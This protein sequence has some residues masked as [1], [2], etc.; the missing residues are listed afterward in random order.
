MTTIEMLA[1]GVL[2]LPRA[3]DALRVHLIGIGGSGMAGLAAFLLRRGSSVSGS[4]MQPGDEVRR[5]AEAGVHVAE[6]GTEAIPPDVDLVVRSAAVPDTQPEVVEARRRGVPVVKYA[7]ALGA[8]M[9]HCAGVAISGTHGKSTTTGWLSYVLREAGLDPSFVIG[10]SVPQLG[11][12]SGAGDGPHFVAEACEYDRSFLNLR[13]QRAAILNI[14]EDHLDCYRNLAAIEA[15]FAEFAA[16]VPADGL[17][18][19]NANDASC[20]RV[21]AHATCRVETFG[22]TDAADW[23]ASELVPERGCYAFSVSHRT[24]MLG[25]I[26]VGLPGR[27]N[28]ANA[29]AVMAL[30][31]DCGAQW[32]QIVP[33]LAS[34]RG[35]RRRLELRGKARGVRVL[36][37][38]AHHPTEIRATLAAARQRYEPRQ[39]WCL[40]QPHQHSRTR[41]L[42]SAF[43]ESF[44]QADHVVV[45]DIYFVRDSEREREAV[46][47]EDLV[48]RIRA[49]GDDAE[50]LPSFDS[51][52]TRVVAAAQPGDVVITMGAGNIWK[53]ADEL[54]RR[55]REDLPA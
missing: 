48:E 46:S 49:R 29:L 33:A 43:A 7:Q 47:A 17:L 23:S 45:P 40:F 8:L 38:Y 20:R 51:I 27:H 13:P 5:L 34:F 28:V 9:S 6:P 26:S 41:F 16:R 4:D 2:V 22:F 18:V 36:D 11:G 35:V 42:L 12:G 19:T 54:L 52:V 21:A 1:D 24:K 50:F 25:R 3:L 32:E 10:A 15:A 39:L 53:V 31:T 44:A 14:E 30:A 37:D 55:L